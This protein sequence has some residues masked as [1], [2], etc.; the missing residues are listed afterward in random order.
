MLFNKTLLNIVFCFVINAV[1]AK[2]F[3]DCKAKGALLGSLFISV[4]DTAADFIVVTVLGIVG[5]DIKTY[6][7]SVY[8][9]LLMV[10]LSKSVLFVLT[11][12]AVYAGLYL[13]D[14][15]DA[16]IPAFLLIYPVASIR[17]G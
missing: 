2:L 1:L 17:F 9:Y 8:A 13:R 6:R 12:A 7:S 10:L 15:R 14:K 5:G 3:F 11:K 16:S 4:A